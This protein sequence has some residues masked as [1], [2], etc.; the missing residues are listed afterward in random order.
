MILKYLNK[1]LLTN[2]GR[3]SQ[4]TNVCG[5][6]F[7]DELKRTLDEMEGKTTY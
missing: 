3:I 6:N 7:P 5:Y 4:I 1:Q 2:R